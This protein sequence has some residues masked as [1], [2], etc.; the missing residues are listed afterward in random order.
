MKP[1]LHP[2]FL[3][4]INVKKTQKMKDCVT[5]GQLRNYYKVWKKQELM[6]MIEKHG[7]QVSGTKSELIYFIV[8]SNYAKLLNK[9]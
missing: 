5:Y 4:V 6:E 7:D 8:N 2:T 3:F 1:K 9:N